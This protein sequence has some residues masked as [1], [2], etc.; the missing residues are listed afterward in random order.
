MLGN[1]SSARVKSSLQKLEVSQE[2]VDHKLADLIET[3][4][5]LKKMIHLMNEK[6]KK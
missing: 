3:I 4:K 1:T 6:L 5:E 2:G